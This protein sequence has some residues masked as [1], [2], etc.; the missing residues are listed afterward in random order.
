[1]DDFDADEQPNVFAVKEYRVLKP[2]FCRLLCVPATS[3]PVERIFPGRPHHEAKSCQNGRCP[4][5]NADAPALYWQLNEWTECY[6]MYCFVCCLGFV[7]KVDVWV[8]VLVLR[9]GVLVLVLV[10]KV[11]VLL[12]SLAIAYMLSCTKNRPHRDCH[13]G[14]LQ[15]PR[16]NFD[17]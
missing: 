14:G 17:L 1:M 11:D 5:W 8:L 10:L 2:L 4:A 13:Y 16:S 6:L 9:P 7:L 12:T 3:V 15:V